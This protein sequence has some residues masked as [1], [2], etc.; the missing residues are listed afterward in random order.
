[1]KKILEILKKVFKKKNVETAEKLEEGYGDLYFLI[2][3]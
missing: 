1:M 3:K 2:F